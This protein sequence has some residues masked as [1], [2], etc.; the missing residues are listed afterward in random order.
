MGVGRRT[1]VNWERG[2]GPRRSVLP[3]L[4]A[5]LSVEIADLVSLEEP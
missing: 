1:V 5:V 3:R 4:A 2:I